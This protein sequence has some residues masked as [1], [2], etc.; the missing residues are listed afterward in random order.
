MK[1]LLTI[2]IILSLPFFRMASHEPYTKTGHEQFEEFEVP[3]GR[4][5]YR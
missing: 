2:L 1:T 4:R 5:L 3:R